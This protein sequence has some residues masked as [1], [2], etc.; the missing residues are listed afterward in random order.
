MRLGLA[1]SLMVSVAVDGEPPLPGN[2]TA[3]VTDRDL[4]RNLTVRLTILLLV[5]A[6]FLP[7][8]SQ[9]AHAR[10]GRNIMRLEVASW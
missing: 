3:T 2:S 7:A 5:S 10:G 8:I 9:V 4:K 6:L 1:G